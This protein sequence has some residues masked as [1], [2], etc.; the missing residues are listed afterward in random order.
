MKID[1]KIIELYSPDSITKMLMM[2]LCALIAAISSLKEEE[3]KYVLTGLA[4]NIIQLGYPL[5]TRG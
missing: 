5:P 1:I 3:S 2:R 4:L